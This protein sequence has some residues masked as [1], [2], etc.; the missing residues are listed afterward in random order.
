MRTA[1]PKVESKNVAPKKQRKRET[2]SHEGVIDCA[3][4]LADSGG[5][6][7]LSMRNLAQQLGVEAMSLYNHVANKEQMLDGM[8]ERVMAHCYVPK[9]PGNWQTEVRLHSLSQHGVIL[10][11][12][13]VA[14]LL[15]SRRAGPSQL[16]TCDAVLGCFRA[17]GFSIHLAYRS[18]LTLSSYIYGFVFQEV[19]WPHS[20]SELPEA[21]TQLLPSVSTQELPHVV[22]MMHY[23]AQV[24]ADSGTPR[25]PLEYRAEFE[26]GLDLILNGLTEL[27]LREQGGPSL[28]KAH[29]QPAPSGKR[30]P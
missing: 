14:A 12:P 29:P 9:Y 1:Q 26:F 24:T 17:A 11:H 21:V 23:V 3:I 4:S 30:R 2:L 20:R 22:E 10:K 8:L 19:T 25:G 6:L 15:E 27:M 18:M 7:G 28:L 5:I 13:W 16:A